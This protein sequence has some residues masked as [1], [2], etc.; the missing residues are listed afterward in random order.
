[1]EYCSGIKR[2]EGHELQ[3]GGT[4]ETCCCVKEADT[5]GHTVYESVYMKSAEETNP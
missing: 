1:M 3:R 4:L 2:N 5:K